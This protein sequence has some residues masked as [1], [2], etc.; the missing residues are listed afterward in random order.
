MKPAILAASILATFLAFLSQAAQA[1][2]AGKFSLETGLNYN[3][4]KYGGTQTTN[5]LY[6]PVTG[7]YRVGPWIF[8]LTVPYLRISGPL[9]VIN[10][11]GATGAGTTASSTRSG[12]GDVIA[13][14]TRNIYRNN[15]GFMVSLTGK[16]KF[17][18][19]DSAQGLGTGKN[20]YAIQSELY[21]LTG[22]LTTFGILGYKIY[23]NPSGYTLN[24]TFYGSLGVS[25]KFD[26]ETSGGLMLNLGQKTTT[27]GSSHVEAIMF[28]N[29]KIAESWKA[30]G[31]VL[32]GFTNS[33]PSFG[34]GLNVTY[35]F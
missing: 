2:D 24:N 7:K 3:S 10:G 16:I 22:G 23:G 28:A 12:L 13:A 17:G 27:V 34:A 20:D 15:S 4:G 30:Q 6:I 1:D 19:A 8:K 25:N 11:V 33:V 14:A 5:I 9:N 32:K 31:Y 29:R 18:T 21:Q 35:L 26:Q